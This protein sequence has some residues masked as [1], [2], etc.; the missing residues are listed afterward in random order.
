[1]KSIFIARQR[2]ALRVLPPRGRS[3]PNRPSEVDLIARG[4][5]TGA[6]A[7][8][9]ADQRAFKRGAEQRTADGAN[10]GA[11]ATAGES[12]IAHGVATC[13][14]SEQREEQGSRQSSSFHYQSPR[15]EER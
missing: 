8:G 2:S 5:R 11:N 1:M 4:E 14:Q 6:G 9:A 13:A 3:P 7:D 15:K 10:T 12:A